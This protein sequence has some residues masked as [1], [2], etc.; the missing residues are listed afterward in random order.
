M[1]SSTSSVCILS[2]RFQLSTLKKGSLSISDYFTKIK[3]LHDILSAISHPL[4]TSE[5]TSYLL[6]GLPSSYDSLVTF[7]TT[8]LDLI[9]LD[10]LY[11]HLLTN[12]NCLDQENTCSEFSLP[13]AHLV[14]SSIGRGH[15]GSSSN[16]RGASQFVNCSRSRGRGSIASSA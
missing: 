2:T 12:E 11:G 16:N 15:R 14:T 13:S 10:D 3:H 4:S 8:Q 1:F 7:V 9:S 5:I 6:T